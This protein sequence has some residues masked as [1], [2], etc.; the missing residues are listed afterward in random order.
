MSTMSALK[1]YYK[2]GRTL[3]EGSFAVVRSVECKKDNSKWAAI[4]IDKKNLTR[5][6]EKSLDTEVEIL[7]SL[8]HKVS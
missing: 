2:V 1:T 7:G 4:C 5:D 8:N 3:G 6:D